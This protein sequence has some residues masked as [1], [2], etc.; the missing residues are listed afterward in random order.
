MKSETQ[1]SFQEEVKDI[2]KQADSVIED[3][4]YSE[5]NSWALLITTR[6]IAPFP[7]VKRSALVIFIKEDIKKSGQLYDSHFE[8]DDFYYCEN[9]L[10]KILSVKQEGKKVT[11]T[12]SRD[13]GED[14]VFKFK[15]P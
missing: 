3:G 4:H 15:L 11:A 8:G 9:R 10:V 7:D 13:K 14:L 1:I 5:D 2:F 6:S 12:V